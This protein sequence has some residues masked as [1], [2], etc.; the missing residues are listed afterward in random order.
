VTAPAGGRLALTFKQKLAY[1]AGQAGNVLGYSLVTGFALRFYLPPTSGEGAGAPLVPAVFAGFIPVWFTLNLVARGLDSWWDPYVA[2]WSD[3]S[4]HRL[5]RRRVFM[6]V[7]CLP[8]AL[9]TAGIFFPPDPAATLR[10]AVFAG[11]LLTVYYGMFSVYV[12]PYLALLPELAPDPKENIV[13]STL[14]AAAALLG[15]LIALIAGPIVAQKVGIPAMSAVFAVISLGLL[16]VPIVSIDERRLAVR[17]EGPASTLGFLESIKETLRDQ[18][19]LP[20]V[21]GSTL[22][23]FGF[24][25]I[26]SAAP[27]YVEV[28]MQKPLDFQAIAMA[29]TFGVAIVAFPFVGGA[30][31]KYGKRRVMIF[32]SVLLALILSAVPLV[33]GPASGVAL[34]GASGVSVS[35]LLA[36]PNAMLA[37]VC[38]ASAR[39]TGQK[40]E[41][42]FFGAQGLLQKVSL[43]LSTG[44][45]GFLVDRFGRSIQNPLGVKLSGPMASL[46]LLAAAFFFFRYPERRVLRDLASPEGVS[47]SQPS[48]NT[49]TTGA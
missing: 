21:I 8:L 9:A 14:Q 32:G 2:N 38:N 19:F 4:S 47:P 28:L 36:V 48:P 20:Y 7:G 6:I 16:L 23:W 18:S 42:M 46:A 27:Y 13:L 11:A 37:D 1:A 12:A 39:R 44:L 26:Q 15:A 10:N 35:I 49:A 33:S 29:A 3:K 22:F 41:A 31:G 45:L 30:V 17:H 5:G 43:G 24:N 25:I 34:L 40:R